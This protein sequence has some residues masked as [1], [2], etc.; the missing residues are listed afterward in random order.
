MT[1]TNLDALRARIADP[2]RRARPVDPRDAAEQEHA[3]LNA[4]LLTELIRRTDPSTGQIVPD[5]VEPTDPPERDTTPAGVPA[6]SFGGGVQPIPEGQ[7]SASS[8]EGRIAEAA[9]RQDWA[10]LN[11]LN[12]QLLANVAERKNRS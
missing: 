12:A 9:A 7:L 10:T 5:P 3:D 2:A 8:L 6:G 11:Q 1:K 4:Q